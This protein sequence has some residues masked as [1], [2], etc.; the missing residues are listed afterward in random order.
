MLAACA[1]DK[2]HLQAAVNTINK[3]YEN[4]DCKAYPDFREMMVR[5]DKASF[6][7][8]LSFG[9]QSLIPDHNSSHSSRHPNVFLPRGC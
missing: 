1:L 8:P 7:Y 5:K 3:N 4:Q 9:Y 2:N 6:L